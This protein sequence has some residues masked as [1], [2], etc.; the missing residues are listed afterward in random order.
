MTRV[1]RARWLT[2]FLAGVVHGRRR[3][4]RRPAPART[5]GVLDPRLIRYAGER[6]RH[7]A[8]GDR[9][10]HHGLRPPAPGRH[11]RL[12][13]HPQR[14]RASTSC[15][16][17]L[18][19]APL[20]EQGRPGAGRA[21]RHRRD[22]PRACSGSPSTTTCWSCWPR[23]GSGPPART[24]RPGMSSTS[25]P[26]TGGATSWSRRGAW[27]RP[28]TRWP[29]PR[30]DREHALQHRRPQHG[31]PHR[32]LLPAL[33]HRGAGSRR[34]GDLGGRAPH[35]QP[36]P[37]RG[38]ERGRHP[39]PWRRCS[40]ATASASRTRRS[41][42]PWSRAC[43]RSTSSCPPTGAPALVDH[44]GEPI[45]ADLH[46]IE[47][48]GASAGGPSARPAGGW[49]RSPTAATR[50]SYAEFL[51]AALAARP[52]VPRRAG[53]DARRRPARSKVILLGGDCLPTLAR[54]L[55]PEKP[56]RPALRAAE[57]Q[58]GG[59]DV[60]RRRRPRH[61]RQRARLAPARR[62]RH[63]DGLRLSRGRAGVLRQ[64]RP[65]RHLQRAD[66]PE[67]AA[68]PAAS[69]RSGTAVESRIRRVD[70]ER[71]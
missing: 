19:P 1:A 9:P 35:P 58:G 31:R 62:R 18:R 8:G 57:P 29:T 44:T 48:W 5:G 63:R 6:R 22:R 46:D 42:A 30:G 10:R 53:P 71:G 41:P 68:A 66:V 34:A 17:P 65:S 20:R 28:W 12:A 70:K 24:A 16:L 60:R 2:P 47:T 21:A 54:A 11:A 52:R 15:S 69:A 59:G 13:E 56:G 39:L 3:A 32:A 40:S 49:S 43:R 50:S 64:R 67:R 45:D 51:D 33:R 37:G 14:G 61:A 36:D 25:S 38:P 55:V 27:T 23:S 7:P 4:G 26:T